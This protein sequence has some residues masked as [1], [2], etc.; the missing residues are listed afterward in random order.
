[1]NTYTAFSA[2]IAFGND[3]GKVHSYLA[4]PLCA[5]SVVMNLINA[6]VL[7]SKQIRSG[8]N[9]FLFLMSVCYCVMN[10]V[11]LV[12]TIHDSIKYSSGCVSHI[13]TYGWA[14]TVL[15]FAHLSFTLHC[16]A[17]WL[18]VGLALFRCVQLK[19]KG[20]SCTTIAVAAKCI[21][22]ITIIT[23]LMCLPNYCSFGI[24]RFPMEETT[25]IAA[26]RS[27]TETPGWV[28]ESSKISSL[29][30]TLAIA[31]LLTSIVFFIVPCC[32]LVCAFG[33]LVHKLA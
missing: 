1:M 24:Q 21:G 12:T 11:Y 7:G 22:L 14:V 25:C 10:L 3:Y 18:T 31:F 20:R 30:D 17:T 4:I 32:L 5:V 29:V 15:I 23:I 27:D 9:S 26:N 33:Y 28:I 19:T 16:L 2:I 6:A 8:T 13:F